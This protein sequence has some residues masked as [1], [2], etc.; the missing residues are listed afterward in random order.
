MGFARIDIIVGVHLG[1]VEMPRDGW[2]GPTRI[3]VVPVRHHQRVEVLDAAIAE[4]DLPAARRLPFAAHDGGPEA[5]GV[6]QTEMVHEGFEIRRHLGMA[7][8]IRIVRWHREIPKRHLARRG[9]DMQRTVGRG[10]AVV[11]DV[12]LEGPHAADAVGGFITDVRQAIGLEVAAGSDPAGA[13]A[14]D[15]HARQGLVHALTPPWRSGPASCQLA[16]LYSTPRRQRQDAPD[17]AL[18]QNSYACDKSRRDLS[19]VTR[20][21]GRWQ[22]ESTWTTR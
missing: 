4:L 8:E 13:G 12:V 20:R 7:G 3:P 19:A 18:H 11:G 9:V 6:A 14:D 21:S 1:A 16:S 5:Y 15:A 17:R 10:F 2:I 22:Q